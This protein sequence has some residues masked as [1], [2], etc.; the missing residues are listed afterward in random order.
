MAETPYGIKRLSL[1]VRQSATTE[2]DRHCPDTRPATGPTPAAERRG[3]EDVQ[4]RPTRTFP[5]APPAVPAVA[6]EEAFD[7]FSSARIRHYVPVLGFKRASRRLT[8]RPLK[9]EARGG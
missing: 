3:R 9:S 6:T 4:G 8:Q 2:R 5:D 7:F 1:P